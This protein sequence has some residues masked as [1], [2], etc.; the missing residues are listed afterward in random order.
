MKAIQKAIFRDVLLIYSL[1][2]RCCSEEQ[3]IRDKLCIYSCNYQ[4]TEITGPVKHHLF[5]LL[6]YLGFLPHHHT[7]SIFLQ[8]ASSVVR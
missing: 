1:L 5:A 2:Q 4:I 7:V 8:S 6:A 3:G